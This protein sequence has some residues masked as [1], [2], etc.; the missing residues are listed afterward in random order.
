MSFT[1]RW[2]VILGITYG[3]TAYA[4][5][6]PKSAI[7]N[8]ATYI[9]EQATESRLIAED[10]SS[11][12]SEPETADKADEIMGLQD[13][14][15]ESTSDIRTEL[16]GVEDTTPWW[17]R[18]LQQGAISLTV[19]G[20]VIFLWQTGLGMFIKKFFWSLGLFIPDRAMRSAKIDIKTMD[21]EHPLSVNEGCAVRR[22]SDPAYEYARKKLK[23]EKST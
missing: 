6:S 20:V 2:K 3:V 15:I 22:S 18:F 13:N 1:N 23:Q 12:T 11:T 21:K 19:L 16:H 7:D 5:T 4:C 14:I 8:A 17:G 9:S 10:I